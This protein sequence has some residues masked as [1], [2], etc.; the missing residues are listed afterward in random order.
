MVY[1]K[2][3]GASQRLCASSSFQGV[4]QLYKNAG[5]RGTLESHI[6]KLCPGNEGVLYCICSGISAWNGTEPSACVR[7][8][9]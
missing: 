9:L 7:Q 5:H 1:G 2:P 3:V 8:I 6:Y 4:E